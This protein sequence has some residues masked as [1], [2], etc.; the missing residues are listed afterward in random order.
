MYGHRIKKQYL[1]P[2]QEQWPTELGEI[3]QMIV[4]VQELNRNIL[5]NFLRAD[6]NISGI[7]N[8]FQNI[9]ILPQE[10]LVRMTKESQAKRSQYSI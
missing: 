4:N 1:D 7:D 3:V 8:A 2:F 9:Q 10:T 5:I 6:Y